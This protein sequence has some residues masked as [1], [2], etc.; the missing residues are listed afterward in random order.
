MSLFLPL[1]GGQVGAYRKDKVAQK[2]RVWASVLDTSGQLVYFY[3]M[4]AFSFPVIDVEKTS[5]KLKKIRE[6]KNIKIGDLQKLFNF[7]HPQAIYEWEN[8][9]SKILPRLDNLVVLARLYK[10]PIDEL[11]ALKTVRTELLPI[12]EQCPPPYGIAQA[13]IDFI[14]LNSSPD[15][16]AA[17]C[18]HF[19]ISLSV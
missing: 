9:D 11:V 16:Q 12:K 7:D 10:V 1:E 3:R 19:N 14:K 13:D 5:L 2:S 18:R 4:R 8:P 15:I 17:L 6:K